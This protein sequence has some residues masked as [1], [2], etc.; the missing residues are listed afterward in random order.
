MALALF[1]LAAVTS[2]VPALMAEQ[3]PTR[4]RASGFA[5]PYSIAVA[6]TG[7]TAPYLQTFLA[8][9]GLSTLFIGY[10]TTDG[11]RT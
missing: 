2:I 10:S 5:F 6:L 9:Q 3:F 7:G 1:V 4:V 11:E 8:G